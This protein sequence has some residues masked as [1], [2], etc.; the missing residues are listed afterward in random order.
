MAGW[1][2]DLQPAVRCRLLGA[3]V[4]ELSDSQ[5]S[6]VLVAAREAVA[7]AAEL[8]DP[9]LRAATLVTLAR[10]L[11]ADLDRRERAELG[12]ELDRLGTAHD[13]PIH[14]W[15]GRYFLATA[16]AAGGEVAAAR[17]LIDE[18][19]ELAGS[20]RMPGPG[21][22][23]DTMVATLAHIEGRIGEAEAGYTRAAVRMARQGSPYADGYLA[24]ARMTLRAS[25]GRLGEMLPMARQM[26]EAFGPV[27]VDLLAV[28]LAAAGEHQEARQVVAQ[29]GPIRAD[30]FFK[31]FATF[32]AMTLVML[33]ET[34]GAA[35]LY[36]ALLPY[37]AA[38]PPSAG[39]TAATRPVAYT[40]AELATL[41]G[42]EADAE[43]YYA[44]AA[45]IAE[46][47]KRG[48]TG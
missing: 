38:S 9:A 46:Q 19:V 2:P 22:V 35:E 8:G 30:Y 20:Y 39:F 7:L 10:E 44:R 15:Y 17:Q 41:L 37:A 4:A 47:W 32:R 29:A 27:T 25:E 23:S 14:R 43:A 6:G 11:D 48:G 18:C 26:S 21:A 33:G 13:L 12:R 1:C 31:V 5:D 34:R 16:A 45:A 24:I 28:V 42:R 36:E 40:L 3:Y